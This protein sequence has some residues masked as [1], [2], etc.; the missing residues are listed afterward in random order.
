MAQDQAAQEYEFKVKREQMESQR[1]ALEVEGIRNYASVAQ[2][3]WFRDYLRYIE[4]QANY[5]MAK[6]PNAKLIFLGNSGAAPKL[7]L[8]IG[9]P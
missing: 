2:A 5:D 9:P 8:A 7:D 6:S 1:R 3:P 4:I